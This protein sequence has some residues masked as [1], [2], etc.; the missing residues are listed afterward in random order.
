MQRNRDRIYGKSIIDTNRLHSPIDGPWRD[1]KQT[2]LSSSFPAVQFPEFEQKESKET[3]GKYPPGPFHNWSS[4]CR[5][6]RWVSE[7]ERSDRVSR[8]GRVSRACGSGHAELASHGGGA[9][10]LADPAGEW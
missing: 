10:A 7:D 6:T 9:L 3:K 5:L 4:V 2:L 1:V 8:Q